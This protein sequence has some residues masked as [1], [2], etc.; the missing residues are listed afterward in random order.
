MGYFQIGYVAVLASTNLA[1]GEEA[2]KK[3]LAYQPKDEDPS[4]PRADY[5]LGGIYEKQGRKAEAK[6]HYT[7]SL[8]INPNRQD[9]E[10]AMTRDSS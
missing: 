5:W 2:L 7:S 8:K 9:A 3:Y 1:R 6:A 10:Q 4:A